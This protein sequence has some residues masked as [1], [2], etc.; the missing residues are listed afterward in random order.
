MATETEWS[1]PIC[2]D[3][4]KS[5]TFV[6]P[7]QHQFCLGCILR[8]AQRSSNCPLCRAEMQ[9][10]KFSVREEEDYLK[11]TI[12][13]PAQPLVAR[14]AGRASGH[15]ANSNPHLPGVSTASQAMLSP[16]EE[17]A[18][19]TEARAPVGSLL[20]EAWGTLFQQHEHL[21]DPVRPWLRQKLEAIYEAEWWRITSLESLTV[22][23]LCRCGL[24][25]E[26]LVQ[27][28][29]SSFRENTQELVQ[30]L[31]KVIQHRCSKEARRLLRSQAA[32]EESE[33]PV[34]SSSSSSLSGSSSPS[35]SISLSSSSS[36]S[37]SRVGTPDSSLVSPSSPAGSNLEEQPGPSCPTHTEQ[38]QP[39]EEPREAAAA[40]SGPGQGRHS[41]PGG[42]QRP[43]KRRD[44]SPQDSA[45]PHKRLRHHRQH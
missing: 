24:V 11:Y 29:Q 21:L 38:E 2:R 27:Q 16:A 9:V 42:P 23:N 36:S 5:V 32:R 43:P 1:C 13:G 10:L 20:P 15:L 35:S 28:L 26:A 45:R 8:W 37:S 44:P 6:Q 7:C 30:D 22:C 19:G 34:T 41:S 39:Q 12:S 18:V 17:G 3:D 4:Q 33:S 25:Q 14:R 40:P 31:I